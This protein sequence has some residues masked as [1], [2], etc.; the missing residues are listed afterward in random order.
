MDAGNPPPIG[1]KST[2]LKAHPVFPVRPERLYGHLS[3]SQSGSATAGGA[4][5]VADVCGIVPIAQ[6][7]GDWLEHHGVYVSTSQT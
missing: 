4:S 6:P 5:W 2:G 1:D 3:M 7:P